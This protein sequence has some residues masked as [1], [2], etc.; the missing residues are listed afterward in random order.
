MPSPMG[1]KRTVNH[2]LPPGM[3]RKRGRYYYGRQESALGADLQAA[4]KRWAELRGRP[5]TFGDAIVEYRLRELATKAPK[6]QRE[7]D[8]QLSL[9]AK[10]FGRVS[11][12]AMKPVDIRTYLD[13]RRAKVSATREKALLSA[14]FNFA[15]GIGLTDAVNPCVGIKGVGS[16]REVYVEDAELEAVLAHAD[17]PLRGFLELAY[18]TGQDAAVLLRMTRADVRD[19]LLWARRTKT[20]N[21][22]RIEIVGPLAT[23][24]TRL[25]SNPVPS[26]YLIADERGQPMTLQAM[27]RR[28]WKA[29]A[30]AGATFQIRDLRA[31]AGSDLPSLEQAQKLL[32]HSSEAT[33]AGYRRRRI[34]ERATPVLKE[35]K[36]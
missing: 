31:K 33:T 1:R 11:L 6:T 35:I 19:G 2:D 8:R 9:L 16:H 4:L 5:A 7:Y 25:A 18:Y 22:T 15:R 14:V 12:A 27:R 34:G 26:V 32:A 30:A 10:V 20:E 23:I 24:L 36:R 21:A 13:R 17:R 29:R 3:Y 28:F